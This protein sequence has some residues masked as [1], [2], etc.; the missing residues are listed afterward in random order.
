MRNKGLRTRSVRKTGLHGR[1]VCIDVDP[2]V[3]YDCGVCLSMRIVQSSMYK[4]ITVYYTIYSN[5]SENT[6]NL[7]MM[8]DEWV[9]FLVLWSSFELWIWTSSEFEIHISHPR[10]SD[11]D[12][13]RGCFPK[14][15]KN[16][17]AKG[18]AKAKAGRINVKATDVT[19]DDHPVVKS[20]SSFP[21]E[22]R[23]PVVNIDATWSAEDLGCKI[24]SL[25]KQFQ[26]F[27]MRPKRGKSVLKCLDVSW[28][29]RRWFWKLK[30]HWRT[31]AHWQLLFWIQ[32]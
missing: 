31:V 21:A 9:T 23:I 3:S 32:T 29:F 1:L 15:L 5:Y 16:A 2:L 30:P 4:C 18:K 28:Q 11:L 25:V 26:P 24:H 17:E 6:W 8:N 10:F 7:W 13:Y 19:E 27:I 20:I 12:S 14:A 22:R